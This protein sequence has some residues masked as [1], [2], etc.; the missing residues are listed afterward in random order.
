MGEER[1][2]GGLGMIRT[3]TVLSVDSDDDDKWP[4]KLVPFIEWLQEALNQI[5]PAYRDSADIELRTDSSYDTPCMTLKV[6]YDRPETAEEIADREMEERVLRERDKRA[7][8]RAERAQYERLRR[9]YEGG[10]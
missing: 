9:K 7:T 1:G 10:S 2:T 4:E 8:E 3:F 5:S 6:T